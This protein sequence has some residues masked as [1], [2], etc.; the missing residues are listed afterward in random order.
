MH[1]V[2]GR[3]VKRRHLHRQFARASVSCFGMQVA[4]CRNDADEHKDNQ[5]PQTHSP[6]P[7]V[8]AHHVFEPLQRNAVIVPV[9]QRCHAEHALLRCTCTVTVRTSKSTRRCTKYR[10]Q[11]GI[12]YHISHALIEN[13]HFQSMGILYQPTHTAVCIPLLGAV[14]GLLGGVTWLSLPLSLWWCASANSVP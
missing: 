8:R 12:F 6:G 5:Q 7:P 10:A 11:M 13:V 3:G 14:G 2:V 1:H 4:R 9:L